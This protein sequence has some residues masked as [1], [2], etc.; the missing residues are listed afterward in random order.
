[1]KRNYIILL[2]TIITLVLGA[3]YI[4]ANENTIGKKDNKVYIQQLEEQNKLLLEALDN[5]GA[6]SKDEAVQIYAEGVKTRSGP[7]QYSVMCKEQKEEF[8]KE[9]KE[10]KNY[11]W[12]TGFSSPWV[13]EYKVIYDKKNPD[14]SYTVTL[15][16]YWETSSGPFNESDTTLTL[17]EDNGIWCITDIQSEHD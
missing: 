10:N 14:N 3:K 12:V 7:L 4:S 11:S 16:F 13:R 5:F 6:R 2:L 17:K 15:K 1:M 8:M 9:L